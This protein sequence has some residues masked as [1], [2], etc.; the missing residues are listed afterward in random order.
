MTVFLVTY[1]L[2]RETVRPNITGAIDENFDWARLSESSYAVV[3]SDAEA[4]YNVL[5]PLT[6]ENDNLYVIPLKRPYTGFGPKVVN[7]WLDSNLT[8]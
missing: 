7:D 8:Y 2:N 1:D 4:I 6:D 3:G 5:A